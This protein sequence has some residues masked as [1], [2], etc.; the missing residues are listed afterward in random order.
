MER[1]QDPSWHLSVGINQRS[2][3]LHARGWPRHR[4]HYCRLCYYSVIP[5]R[6]AAS[7]ETHGGAANRVAAT[8]WSHQSLPFIGA[9]EFN[10]EQAIPFTGRTCDFAKCHVKASEM[11]VPGILFFALAY[12]LPALG[13][14]VTDPHASV[15]EVTIRKQPSWLGPLEDDEPSSDRGSRRCSSYASIRECRRSARPRAVR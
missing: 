11:K 3:I 6:R 13:Q 5:A 9:S 1:I 7:L 8:D 2:L 12:A 10:W 14:H 15:L 4:R